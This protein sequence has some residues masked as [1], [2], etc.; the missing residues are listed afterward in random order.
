MKNKKLFLLSFITIF[1]LTVL[2]AL[3][4][5]YKRTLFTP[6]KSADPT[7]SVTTT[8]EVASVDKGRNTIQTALGE[9]H[10]LCTLGESSMM[11]FTFDPN[12]P[13]NQNPPQYKETK[14]VNIMEHA[15]AGD[16]VNYGCFGG[17]C[18]KAVGF[19]LLIKRTI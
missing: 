3:Y 9:V 13:V 5:T 11:S 15:S 1:L 4:L 8:R 17:D 18:S 16:S 2:S 6:M 7:P 19:C 10:I 12:L 14:G